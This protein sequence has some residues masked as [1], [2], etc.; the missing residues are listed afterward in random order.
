MLLFQQ[1][2]VW[3]QRGCRLTLPRCLTGGREVLQ[4]IPVLRAQRERDGQQPRHKLAA[5]RRLRPEA[6]P[7]PDHRRAQGAVKLSERVAPPAGLQN[8]A[9]QFPGTRL[10]D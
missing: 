6:G 8:R 7:P 3:Q 4:H 9:C 10:L 1:R 5:Q 2:K